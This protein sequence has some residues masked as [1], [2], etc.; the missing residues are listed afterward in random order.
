MG[1]RRHAAEH[2]VGRLSRADLLRRRWRWSRARNTPSIST[3]TSTTRSGT[4][5]RRW[6]YPCGLHA[7]CHRAR[8]RR[9]GVHA[10]AHGQD[11]EA[12]RSFATIEC[13]KWV[14]AA[15][16]AFNG[17]VWQRTRTWSASLSL[18]NEDAL[19][20]GLDVIVRA[21]GEDWHKGRITGDAVA[22]AF[23]DLDCREAYRARAADKPCRGSP[24][25]SAADG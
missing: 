22:Q 2:H 20:A 24:I 11:F 4:R 18:L 17:S 9:P 10:Q 15:R 12:Q 19:R 5:P 3:T 7:A 25:P 8:R 16:A 21:T 1:A 23:A 6:H 14:G 13:G